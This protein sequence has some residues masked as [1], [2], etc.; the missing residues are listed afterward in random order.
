MPSMELYGL[1]LET[2]FIIQNYGIFLGYGFIAAMV[3]LLLLEV[4]KKRE[5]YG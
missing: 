5:K 4:F 1:V 2:V 3:F